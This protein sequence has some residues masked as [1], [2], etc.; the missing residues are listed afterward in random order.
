MS[1]TPSHRPTELPARPAQR[2]FVGLKLFLT[3]L[4]EVD[5]DLTRWCGGV[6]TVEG[7]TGSCCPMSKNL[8]NPDRYT[9]T[10]RV[11]YR[12]GSFNK[13]CQLCQTR[14]RP[15]EHPERTSLLSQ[16]P[17]CSTLLG[18]NCNYPDLSARS[19]LFLSA[20]PALALREYQTRFHTAIIGI[21]K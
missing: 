20:H 3:L 7:H 14:P 15:A 16:K 17:V 13:R 4:A 2:A 11:A 21:G 1:T 9:W 12:A 6:V 8:E 10:Q 18:Q 19:Q 5:L